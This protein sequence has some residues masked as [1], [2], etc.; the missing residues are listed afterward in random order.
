M[1]KLIFLI[2]IFT[3]AIMCAQNSEQSVINQIITTYNSKDYVSF[4]DLLSP[5]FK[6]QMSQNDLKE[7]LNENI[8]NYYGNLKTI[9][10]VSE[11][12][13]QKFYNSNFEK[14]NLD[15]LLVFNKAFKID[16]LSFTPPKVESQPKSNIASNNKMISKLDTIVDN[17][18]KTHILD[19]AN[20]GISLSI[21][22]NGKTSFYHYGETKQ[23]TNNLPKNYTIY[24]IGSV[25]K[26]FTGILLAQ[27]ISDNKIKLEDDIRKFL[28]QKFTNLSFEEKPILVKHLINHTSTL[29]RLP[30]NLSLQPNYDAENPYLNYSKAMIFDY[31]INFEMK[32]QPGIN[33]EYSNFGIAVLGLVLEN[34]YKKPFDFLVTKYISK[35]FQMTNTY[36]NVPQIEISNFATGYQKDGTASKH[37]DLVNFAA[38]GGI[39]S[40]IDDMSKFLQENILETNPNLKLSH[41]PTYINDKQ[42]TGLAWMINKTKEGNTLIWHNGGTGGFTSFCGFIK[43]KKCGIVILNNS[44]TNVD[45]LAISILK[46]LP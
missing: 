22:Q 19:K 43:E 8:Y 37:W 12:N 14:G 16:G 18:V 31:L 27:A 32:I 26:T 44:T 13:G 5:D 35:P 11:K 1:K 25:S 21:I 20:V 24:E 4:Y 9:D 45:A 30:E 23:E 6:S 40:T 33:Q 41:F 17:L 2:C 28:P 38:A 15:L 7:F 46:K 36:E 42:S 39:K 10:F 34:I 29:P 3:P